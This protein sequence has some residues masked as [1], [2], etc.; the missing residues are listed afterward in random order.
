M[1]QFDPKTFAQMTF[2][3]AN[4]TK[5]IP[6][7]AGDHAAT[8][9]KYEIL[10][11]AAKDDASKNGLKMNIF[12]NCDDPAVAAQTMRDQNVVR[13][14]FFLDLNEVGLDM[15]E[16]KNIKLGRL[17]EAVGLNRPGEP[18]SFDMLVG[19]RAMVAVTHRLTADGD[20][21]AEAKSVAK[22]A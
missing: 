20:P 3:E 18:F 12:F 1:T 22:L 13:H 4:S 11:W 19:Q 14:E 7:P 17:R 6:V 16:G 5:I 9:T 21:V 10:A 8:I 2:K 15:G